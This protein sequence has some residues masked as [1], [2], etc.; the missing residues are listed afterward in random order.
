MFVY[1]PAMEVTQIVE[2]LK[3]KPV[4]LSGKTDL[5]KYHEAKFG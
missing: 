3:Q 4:F 2:L 1:L 5:L